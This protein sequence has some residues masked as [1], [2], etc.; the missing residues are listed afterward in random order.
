MGAGYS[1]KEGEHYN[2]SSSS[3]N[4]SND[5]PS[6]SRSPLTRR[7]FRV[8]ES[9]YRPPRDISGPLGPV[10]LHDVKTYVIST[11]VAT[12]AA[13][14]S[15]ASSSASE[16]SK[17]TRIKTKVCLLNFKPNSHTLLCGSFLKIYSNDILTVVEVFVYICM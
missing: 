14:V 1:K 11:D 7:F 12:T 3:S 8:S 9:T 16:K 10:P 4:I 13:N 6:E 15:V 17:T 2:I 5:G